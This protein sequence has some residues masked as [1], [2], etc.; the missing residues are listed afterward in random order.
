[1]RYKPAKANLPRP[2]YCEPELG[3]LEPQ[4]KGRPQLTAHWMVG[5]DGKLSCRWDV[6]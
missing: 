2:F 3:G 5:P 1:M 4:P 6:G